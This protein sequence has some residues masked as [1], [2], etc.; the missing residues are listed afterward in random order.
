V[1]ENYKYHKL[2]GMGYFKNFKDW[3]L[4]KCLLNEKQQ[5]SPYIRVGEIRWVSFGTNVGSEIDGK[6]A[7]F[8][9]PAVILHVIGSQLALAIPLSTK[10]KESVGYFSFELNEKEV[11]L[12]AHQ[13][14]VISQKRIFHRLSKLSKERLNWI[15]KTIVNFYDLHITTE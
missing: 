6:G 13:M 4:F 8:T 1:V 10:I 2:E 7:Q 11:S 15:R 14:R 5:D 3:F 9:R 12:C